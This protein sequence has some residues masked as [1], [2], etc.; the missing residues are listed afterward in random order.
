MA[1]SGYRRGRYQ[2][3]DKRSI[4]YERALEHI[5]EAEALSRE[6]GG[7]DQD[8]KQYFF[9]LSP[10]QLSEILDE[11]EREFGR[12]IREYAE[13]TLP[14]WRNGRVH[15]SG[16][17]AE[18]LFNLLPPTMPL[19]A[20]FRLTESLWKHV[21]AS[22]NKK[23]YVGHDVNIEE[24]SQRVKE[25]LEE[26]VTHYQIPSSMEARFNWLSQGDVGVKQQLLNHFR[27]LEKQLLSDALRCQLPVLLNH[28]NSEKGNL[29]T[30][31]AQVLKVGKHEV[32]VIVN[33]RISGVSES[34][35]AR[36]SES[37]DYGWIW[38]VAGIIFVLWLLSK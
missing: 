11:Y 7:T 38:W 25:H 35:P 24:I 30:H 32:Q 21:G 1:R 28:L 17:V 20:K 23:Y 18:R 14:S 16:M 5:R 33:E 15:M 6:L 31:A 10:V 2:S 22:S 29:T 26:V 3:P 37:S 36:P 8:V 27:Q 9:S 34:A 19:E 4:G 13:K 12:S